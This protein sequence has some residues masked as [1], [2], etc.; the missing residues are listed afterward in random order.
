MKKYQIILFIYI[1]LTV[2]LFSSEKIEVMNG[3]IFRQGTSGEELLYVQKEYMVGDEESG[4]ISHHYYARGE[5]LAAFETVFVNNG[6]LL[7]YK[8]AIDELGFSGSLRKV[9][10]KLEIIREKN[11][12]IRTKNINW[13]DNIVVG[14]MLS[15]FIKDN[16]ELLARGEALEFHLPY[17]DIMALIPMRLKAAKGYEDVSNETFAIEMTLRSPLLRLLI[18]PVE[19]ILDR[20]NGSVLQIHGPTILPEPGQGNPNKFIDADIFY[21]YGG[22]M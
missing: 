1:S 2:S 17:F 19:M 12:K 3:N 9:D 22:T 15:Y 7:L 10:D 5:E 13:K 16:I 4:E 6:E 20:E 18:D 8:T 21:S 14:P 11:G